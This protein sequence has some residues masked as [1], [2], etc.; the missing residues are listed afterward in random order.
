MLMS[1]STNTNNT[2][3]L[4]AATAAAA[5]AAA[6]AMA[7]GWYN[8]K[9]Q[10]KKYKIPSALL[11]SPYGEELK[12]AVKLALQGTLRFSAH[13]CVCLYWFLVG[14]SSGNLKASQKKNLNGP[15]SVWRTSL[16]Y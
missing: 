6:S 14:L 13:M 4:V 10:N 3:L 7:M 16:C 8:Q 5:S 9:Q 15:F 2:L 1:P 11:K 12:L